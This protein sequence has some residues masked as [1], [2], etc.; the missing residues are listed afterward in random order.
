[1]I[2]LFV[3]RYHVRWTDQTVPQLLGLSGM[4]DFAAMVCLL[5]A[6]YLLVPPP[7]RG[8]RETAALAGLVAGFA[9]GL[10]PSTA[11]FLA[12]P[13]VAFAIVRRYRGAVAFAAGLA[14]A[15]L[16]LAVWKYRG[17]GTLPIFSSY[18]THRARGR[19]PDRLRPCRHEWHRQVRRPRLAA[20]G[21][22]SRRYP[23]VLLEQSTGRVAPRSPA[24]WAIR[25]SPAKAASWRRGS[26]PTSSSRARATSRGRH[27]VASGGCSARPGRVPAARPV[28]RRTR[29]DPRQR[30]SSPSRGRAT[31]CVRRTLWAA[32]AVLGLLPLVVVTALP[33]DHEHRGLHDSARN[34][35][36]ADRPIVPCR[37]DGG[38][39]P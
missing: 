12:G 34:L 30:G 21:P 17:L 13:V 4:G 5:C 10:K 24:L 19:S 29:A 2:P 9:I 15:V 8:R 14:P 3:G 27:G 37:R 33:R 1:M 6:A 22:E 32:V 25:K 28:D 7:R 38:R 18:G 39:W 31:A 26:R 11:L 20:P 23:R 36:V 35:Y 16:T